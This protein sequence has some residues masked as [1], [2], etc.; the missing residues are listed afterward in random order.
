MTDRPLVSVIIPAYRAEATLLGAV[1]SLRAQVYP[2]WEAIVASDDGID[3]LAV[4]AHAGICDERL[5]Q[6]STGVCGSGEGNARNAALAA[7]RGAILCNLDA[8]DEFR[9]DRLEQLIPLALAHGAAVDN[10]GM[11]RSAGQVCKRP[12][13]DA[14]GITPLTVDGILKPRIPLFPVFRRELAGAGWSAVAFAADVLFNLE[15]LCAARSMVVHPESLYLYFKRDGS[16]TQAP[17]TAETAERGYAAILHLLESGALRLS[18]EVRGAA[19]AE[20]TANRRLNR[21]FR[22]CMQSG[23]CA[24]LEDFLDITENGRA[25]WVEAELA[26]LI[27]EPARAA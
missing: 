12:F 3:Y 1:R 5:Q 18:K 19:R 16:I 13:P 6:V 14:Q 7:A 21:L 17:D 15:L 9:A 24:S 2:S 11:H 23:R 8:D 27:E 4:L 22:H 10:T 20:F 25:P 26:R